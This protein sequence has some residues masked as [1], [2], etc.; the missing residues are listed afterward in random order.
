M[1]FYFLLI[2]LKF[3]SPDS[4]HTTFDMVLECFI[5]LE[6]IPWSPHLSARLECLEHLLC[7]NPVHLTV[8]N[9]RLPPV[10]FPLHH[11]QYSECLQH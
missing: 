9:L 2:H 11:P 7:F 3:I 5:F 6:Y 1:S 10:A 8:I 4:L